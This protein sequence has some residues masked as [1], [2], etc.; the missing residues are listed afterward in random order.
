MRAFRYVNLRYDAGVR[1]EGISALYEYLPV[2][3]RGSFRCSEQKLN[4]IWETSRY[5]LHL[6]TR[7]F[8]LDGI[9]RDGWVWSG[10]AYQSYLMNYYSFFDLEVNK[11]TMVALRGKDPVKRHMNGIVD[12]SFIWFISFLDYYLYTGDLNFLR[13]YYPR[14][15][16]LMDFCLGR[17]NKDGMVE[18]LPGDWV[19]VD[20]A[21]FDKEGEVCAEQL[22]LCRSLEAMA[23]IAALLGDEGN[24]EKFQTLYGEL[25]DKILLLFFDPEQGGFITTRKNGVCSSHVT[26]HP[27]ILALLYGYLEGVQ[28]ESVR[29]RVLLNPAIDRITTPYF[30]FF[31]MA[32]LC[33]IGEHSHV[34][35]QIL[36]YWGGMLDLGATTF[37]EEYNP[38]LTGA[39]HYAMYG[40]PFEKSLCHAWGASPI[41]LLG[42]YFLGVRPLTS[43]YE[44]YEVKPSLGM[45]EWMQGT[46]P[47]P[48]SDIH[49]YMDRTT[50][51]V[52]VG[53]AGGFLRFYSSASP[54]VS[55]GKA[56]PLGNTLYEVILDKPGQEY[57]I[58]YQSANEKSDSCNEKH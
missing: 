3:N 45:L 21:D 49:V 15:L 50:I 6:T 41:Y 29:N 26:R 57:V 35:A 37:W 52:R 53:R 25:K 30:R 31:E 23:S 51:K 55:C 24:R 40:S 8:F 2:E 46:V 44:T 11:R 7:E 22:F 32:A 39:A 14:M 47:A 5:T 43:G 42:R 19:F 34:L 27:N 4:E 10:D 56:V 28:L 18:G 12:Y 20:W 48:G 58:K 1:I 16:T 38:A 36:D 9:K 54:I 13:Q 33:E 17:R